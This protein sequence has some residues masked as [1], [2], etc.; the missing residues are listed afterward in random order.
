MKMLGD[1]KV[2]WVKTKKEGRRRKF[3]EALLNIRNPIL[4]QATGK[5][6]IE[7]SSNMKG[8]GATIFGQAS[9]PDGCNYS[10][11]GKSWRRSSAV[12]QSPPLFLIPQRTLGGHQISLF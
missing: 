1:V 3:I 10:E 12:V 5:E 2:F 11:V 8:S 4:T 9:P 7:N 6:V